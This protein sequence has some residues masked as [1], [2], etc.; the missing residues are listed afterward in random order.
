VSKVFERFAIIYKDK[1]SSQL[2]PVAVRD[3]QE[4]ATTLGLEDMTLEL[5][6]ATVD[7]CKAK[8]TWPPTVHEFLQFSREA[9]TE[10]E[11]NKARE[12]GKHALPPPPTEVEVCFSKTLQAIK[13]IKHDNPELSWSEIGRIYEEQKRHA[14]AEKPV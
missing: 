9:K 14:N 10:L 1:W 6:N 7:I 11:S 2:S 4:W 8:S 3:M 5:A 13:R 12:Q